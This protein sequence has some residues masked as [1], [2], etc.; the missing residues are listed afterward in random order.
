M[1]MQD[2][3][4]RTG[5]SLQDTTYYRRVHTKLSLHLIHTNAAAS[6][7]RINLTH[8]HTDMVEDR[9]VHG[10][11]IDSQVQVACL[12]LPQVEVKRQYCLN[13]YSF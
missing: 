3:R 6:Q 13:F 5:D 10:R 8:T 12:R 1:D 2:S 9:T 7:T 4:D 11:E